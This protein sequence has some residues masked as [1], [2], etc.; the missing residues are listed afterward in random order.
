[1][2]RE[3]CAFL[4]PSAGL[5]P[6]R[7]VGESAVTSSG[8]AASSRFSSFISA[9]YSASVIS[10]RVENVVQMLVAAKFFAQLFDLVRGVPLGHS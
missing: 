8:C 9:S 7:C 4:N 1:M 10:G 6:T 5:P 3:C 2:G